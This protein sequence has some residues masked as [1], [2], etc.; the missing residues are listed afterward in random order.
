M[1][2]FVLKPLSEGMC[3]LA[4][5]SNRNGGPLHPAIEDWLYNTSGWLEM[6]W[7]VRRG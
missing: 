3:R 1:L 6:I 4:L 5:W 2:T 7:N